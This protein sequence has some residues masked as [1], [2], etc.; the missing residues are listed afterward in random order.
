MRRDRLGHWDR[1]GS[2]SLC[3]RALAEGP[4]KGCEFDIAVQRMDQHPQLPD[5]GRRL[6]EDWGT[7]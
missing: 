6:N 3:L 2:V 1:M 5:D 7:G 4:R